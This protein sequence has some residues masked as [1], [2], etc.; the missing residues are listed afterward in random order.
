MANSKSKTVESIRVTSPAEKAALEGYLAA[1][2]EWDERYGSLITRAK[3]WRVM[4]FFMGAIVLLLVAGMIA[5][6]ARSRV[7]PFVVAV[8]SLGRIVGEGPAVQTTTVDQRIVRASLIE[9]LSNA[10][11]VTSDSYAQRH[12]VDAVYAGVANS[13]SAF[14][15]ISE[16]YQ[17]DSP[18]MRGQTMTVN[19]DVH[20]ITPIS[21]SSYEITWLETTRDH[22]GVVSAK[23]EW[24]GVFTYV[25]SPPKDE[26]TIRS[27]PLG[28]YVTEFNWNKVL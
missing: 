14:N 2:H 25:V 26:A 5:Q 7:V 6:S 16:F 22:T 24:K 17:A 3:N 1:R 10:R 28:I 27:N 13:S 15:V 4:A 23:Q 8:D 11:N 9:W 21:G 18:F 20:S 12:N 19:V